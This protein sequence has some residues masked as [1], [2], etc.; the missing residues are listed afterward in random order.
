[1]RLFSLLMSLSCLMLV[2]SAMAFGDEHRLEAQAMRG[3]TLI[4][5]RRYGEAMVVFRQLAADYPASPTGTFGEL[6][7]WQTRM[8]E[9]YDFRFSGEYDRVL[10]LHRPIVDAVMAA[11]EPSDW[12]LF[13]CGAS[14]GMQAFYLARQG[15]W[16]KALGPADRAFRALQKLLWQNPRFIDANMGIGLY[17]YWRSVFTKSLHFL[18]FFHD[19]RVEAIAKVEQVAQ[20]GRYATDLA[21]ANLG[22]VYA[23]E[24]RYPEA[25]AVLTAM[26]VRYPE[27]VVLRMQLGQVYLVLKEYPK[28]VAEFRRIGS[29]DPSI[30]KAAFYLGLALTRQGSDLATARQ[31]FTHYLAT[32]PESDWA[33]AAHYWLGWLAERQNDRGAAVTEYQEALR[34][35]PKLKTAKV[36][37]ER[38]GWDIK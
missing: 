10:R 21:R 18:P 31:V 7:I 11:R 26:L 6:S 25:A 12:D 30:T 23:E 5:E 15:H 32:R 3:Q 34:L 36:A 19:Q 22:F 1:M 29:I 8:F 2:A 17:Q 28:A 16:I 35:N 9:N 27:N 14:L 33:A 38:L 37:L 13:V 24:K 4:M 20:Q